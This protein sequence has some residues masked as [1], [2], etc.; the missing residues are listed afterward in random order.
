MAVSIQACVILAS[1]PEL[2]A[3]K[4]KMINNEAIS[5][6]GDSSLQTAWSIVYQHTEGDTRSANLSWQ[7]PI[8]SGQI[9]KVGYLKNGVESNTF[10]FAAPA[11]WVGSPPLDD[12]LGSCQEANITATN[13]ATG[14]VAASRLR[15]G[16]EN[17]A[18]C[19][20]A[21]CAGTYGRF[22]MVDVQDFPFYNGY[23]SS[24]PQC[25]VS[26]SGYAANCDGKLFTI[27]AQPSST[28]QNV[29]AYGDPHLSNLQGKKFDVHDGLHRLVH[30]PR[31]A[32]E[33]EALLKIDADAMMMPG[34]TSCYNVFFQSAMVSGKWVG[35]DIIL[36]HDDAPMGKKRFVLG[37]NGSFH[38][39]SEFSKDAA[40]LKLVGTEP[41]EVSTR[42]RE[43]SA[44]TPG[45][46]DVEFR[47]GRKHP[48]LV[49]VWAS[50]GNN[51]LTGHEDVQYL[52]LEVSNLPENTGGLLGLDAYSRPA[53]SKCGLTSKEQGGIDSLGDLVGLAAKRTERL[54]WRISAHARK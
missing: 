16:R 20:D 23:G 41:V 32:S 37:T 7:R 8:A 40:I 10:S 33:S 46:D 34:E 45:G 28:N 21:D 26:Q 43:K 29:T 11:A 50:R 18:T 31:G 9:L 36:K 54:H 17:F 5:Q 27:W 42:T 1:I 52:N 48:V 2:L 51:E 30:Y 12:G 39:W 47:I 22:C 38:A 13:L 6:L 49:Q 53:G 24:Q 19:G 15:W 3:V 4:T 44:E 14:Q 35:N 25:S